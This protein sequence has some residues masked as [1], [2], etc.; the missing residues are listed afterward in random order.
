MQKIKCN[1]VSTCFNSLPISNKTQVSSA[2]PMFTLAK[3]CCILVNNCWVPSQRWWYFGVMVSVPLC[4]LYKSLL[5]PLQLEIISECKDKIASGTQGCPAHPPRE[6]TQNSKLH[7]TLHSHGIT[8][9]ERRQFV[10]NLK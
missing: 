8:E 10:L 3:H 9:A 5:Q 4:V 2:I 7:L 6:H 1:F